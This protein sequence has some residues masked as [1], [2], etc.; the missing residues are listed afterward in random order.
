MFLP[1]IRP[2]A[3]DVLGLITFS[4][5]LFTSGSPLGIAAL[6]LMPVFLVLYILTRR[7]DFLLLLLS[8]VLYLIP[9]VVR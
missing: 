9:F 7:P 2:E 4:W 8:T 1:T 3:N 5:H 6:C